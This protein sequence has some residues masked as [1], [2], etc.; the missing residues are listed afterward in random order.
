L[1]FRHPSH[2]VN[3]AEKEGKGGGGQI[4]CLVKGLIK[5]QALGKLIC[6]ENEFACLA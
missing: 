1:S 6:C 5:G 4:M 2:R 3:T